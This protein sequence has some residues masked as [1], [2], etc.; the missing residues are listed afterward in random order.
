MSEDPMQIFNRRGMW[1]QAL[2]SENYVIL[3]A[4]PRLDRQNAF[5]L[6]ESQDRKQRSLG[7]TVNQTDSMGV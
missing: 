2:R 4:F 6:I 1:N 3:R 5:A 7:G